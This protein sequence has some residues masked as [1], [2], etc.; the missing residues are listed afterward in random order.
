MAWKWKIV[1]AAVEQEIAF[2]DKAC[3]EEYIKGL[4]QKQEPY[5]IV[6]ENLQDDGSVIVVMRKRYNNNLFLEASIEPVKHGKWIEK[7]RESYLPAKYTPDG[8][9]ILHKYTY[10]ECDQCRRTENIKE[11]YCHCGAKMDGITR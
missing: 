1:Q 10:Y 9:L 7:E 5:Q 8:N 11:P 2:P 3:F 6:S 4:D